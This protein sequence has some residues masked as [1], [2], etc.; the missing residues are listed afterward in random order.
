MRHSP[1]LGEIAI[2][3]LDWT[4]LNLRSIVAVPILTAPPSG[5]ATMDLLSLPLI[6]SMSVGAVLSFTSVLVYLESLVGPAQ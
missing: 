3:E 6:V 1:V 5:L 2:Y 4:G